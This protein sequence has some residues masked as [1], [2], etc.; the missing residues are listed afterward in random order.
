M[1]EGGNIDAGVNVSSDMTG[2]CIVIRS[3]EPC[4]RKKSANTA[5]VICKVCNEQIVW[6]V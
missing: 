1:A 4:M 2:D 5:S 3:C 6:S